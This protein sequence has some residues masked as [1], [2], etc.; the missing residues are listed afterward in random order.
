MHRVAFAAPYAGRIVTLDL[1]K[2]GGQLICQKDSFLCAAKGVSL[3][4]AF[5]KRMPWATISPATNPATSEPSRYRS[6]PPLRLS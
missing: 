5:T 4:I 6:A 3:G 2:L 1:A